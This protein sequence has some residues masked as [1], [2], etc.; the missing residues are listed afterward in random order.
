MELHSE[1]FSVFPAYYQRM[2]RFNLTV[3]HVMFHIWMSNFRELLSK[4]QLSKGKS[5]NNSQFSRVLEYSEEINDSFFLLHSLIFL[6][7][8]P[9]Q[10]P[11]LIRVWQPR[12]LCPIIFSREPGRHGGQQVPWPV[13][14]QSGGAIALPLAHH[15]HHTLCLGKRSVMRSIQMWLF[16]CLFPAQWDQQWE[17]W[18][19]FT[20]NGASFV[21]LLMCYKN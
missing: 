13:L 21:F 16:T 20:V 11:G 15:T 2:M 12:W 8:C 6:V 14:H 19:G 18:P 3:S 7:C 9:P 5:L 1:G 17:S 4:I 10:G